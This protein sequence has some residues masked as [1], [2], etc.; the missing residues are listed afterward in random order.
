[1]DKI[2][3]TGVSGSLGRLLARRLRAEAEVSGVDRRPWPGRPTS[4]S[5]HAVDLRKR[6]F[7]EVLRKEAPRAVVHLSSAT[8]ANSDPRR[9]DHNV[10]ATQKLLAHC[11]R[12]RIERVVVL[13]SAGVYGAAPENPFG[14]EEE[15]ALSASREYPE[16]R[17]L[18]QR[19]SL[20][21]AAMWK[22]PD[23]SI[24]VLRPVHVLGETSQAPVAALLRRRRVP[25]AM[26]FDPP[27][28]FLHERDLVDAVALTLTHKLSGVFNVV[29][30]GQVPLHT[31]IRAC[32]GEP[33]PLPEFL[34]RPLFR[35]FSALGT[36]PAG[37]IDYFK[38]PLIVSGRRFEEATQWKP[39]FGL[40]EIFEAMRA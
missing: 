29:G 20:A 24:A 26:G 22:Y 30:P 17:S 8:G 4:I 31:A 9:H 36:W 32:G 19:D 10:A 27:M 37:V 2:L 6:A 28:Q 25:T 3:I 40:P 39:L 35:R 14:I 15:H 33:W 12:H 18:V 11:A 13:S 23:L 1:M 16:I 21:C 34:V 5:L 7:E 38:Y